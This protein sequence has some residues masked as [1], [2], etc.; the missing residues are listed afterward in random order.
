MLSKKKLFGG[1]NYSVSVYYYS[2]MQTFYL[3]PTWH[4]SKY[5]MNISRPTALSMPLAMKFCTFVKLP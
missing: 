5:K 1:C 3:A 2:Q 4:Q